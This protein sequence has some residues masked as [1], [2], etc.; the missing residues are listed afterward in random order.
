MYYAYA[1]LR[2]SDLSPYY[3]G[4]GSGNR[5][6][7]KNHTVK[8]P[9]DRKYI[10]FLET[11]LTEVGSLAIE[12]RMIRWYGRKDNGTGILRNRTDGGDAPP[13]HTGMKRSSISKQKMKRSHKGFS[14]LKHTAE[15]LNKRTETRRENRSYELTDEWHQRLIE[16]RKNQSSMFNIR[17]C[18]FGKEYESQKDACQDLGVGIKYLK[19]RL[20]SDK[21]IDCYYL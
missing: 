14:G 7:N 20:Q 13:N 17:V 11:N 5:A 3:I 4:K 18:M 6:F 9:T 19:R 15:S 21:F 2:K 10:I 1:Y 12:R 16:N 8:I